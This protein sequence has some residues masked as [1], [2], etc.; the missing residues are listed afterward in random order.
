LRDH[1]PAAWA[2]AV[3]FDRAIRTGH[4]QPDG[5]VQRRGQADLHPSLVPLDRADLSTAEDHGQL[6]LPAGFQ[7]ECHGVCGT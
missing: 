3:V 5:K 4:L 6:S 2:D 1:D 7:A